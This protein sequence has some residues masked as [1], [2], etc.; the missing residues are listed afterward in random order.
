[1]PDMRVTPPRKSGESAVAR[2]FADYD[3]EVRM[4]L[5]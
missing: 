2:V 4:R 3:Y 1:M 5:R